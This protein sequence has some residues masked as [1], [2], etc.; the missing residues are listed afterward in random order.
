MDSNNKNKW[1]IQSDR[2]FTI[3]E[4]IIAMLIAS[5]VAMSGFA[6]FSATNRSYQVQEGVIQAQQSAR[7]ALGRLARDIRMA[8]FGLDKE[9]VPYPITIGEDV[10]TAITLDGPITVF[11]S[12]AGPDR[13]I[14][15]GIGSQAGV[16]QN[17]SGFE[18]N[19]KEQ[20]LLRL[21]SV[22]AFMTNGG[23]FV[24]ERKF[25]TI[26]GAYMLE[27]NTVQGSL[28]QN[29]LRAAKELPKDFKEDS[30]VYIVQAIEYS[31]ADDVTGCSPE[32]P[33]LVSKD[34]TYIRGG[35]AGSAP[36][37]YAENI[38]D[39]QFAFG[40]GPFVDKNGN[41]SY[42]AGDFVDGLTALEQH[43]IQAVR[44]T[45]V[46]RAGQ[47]PLGKKFKRPAVEN[48]PEGDINFY[49]RRVLSQVIDLRNPF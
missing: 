4:L 27:L 49:R 36:Q 26:D 23:A 35:S 44:V 1:D 37:L 32:K 3:I 33:C 42:D 9:R 18:Y 24:P 14:L 41:G 48:H 8:G 30:L 31:I 43:R 13:I 16:L 2:G 46:A 38:E 29:I 21:N 20:Y 47:D 7:A 6:L 25:I 34:Y 28:D 19:Q 22:D 5:V 39:I 45:V 11:D 40:F 15:L 10:G 17:L 12:V